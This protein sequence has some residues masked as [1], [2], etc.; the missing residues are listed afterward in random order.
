MSELTIIV[1]TPQLAAAEE[2]V[3]AK[4]SAAP[5]KRR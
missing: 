1:N 2:H 5:V 3:G 4:N